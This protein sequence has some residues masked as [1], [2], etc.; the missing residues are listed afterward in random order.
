[1]C[2]N[3]QL[4]NTD[5]VFAPYNHNQQVEVPE[6]VL[7]IQRPFSSEDES[8]LVVYSDGADFVRLNKA[9]FEISGRDIA[10]FQG[11]HRKSRFTV[12]TR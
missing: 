4:D 3:G 11:G 1:M 6:G 8:R 12:T 7:V 5:G 10:S 2:T 9:L